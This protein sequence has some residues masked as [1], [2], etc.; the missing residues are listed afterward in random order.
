LLPAC[1][2]A[3]FAKLAKRGDSPID[4]EPIEIP[5]PQH[6][7]CCSTFEL[8]FVVRSVVEG[9]VRRTRPQILIDGDFIDERLPIDLRSLV[10]SAIRSGQH[11]I[12]TC[13][14]GDAGCGGVEE[15]IRVG[16][17]YGSILW[18]YRLPQS[19]DGFGDSEVS[20]Y[21]DWLKRAMRHRRI[22]NRR[23]VV[24]ALFEALSDAE[25]THASDAEYG[26]YGFERKDITELLAKVEKLR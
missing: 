22:F 21:Q 20:P 14:C 17:R 11:Y 15:G 6:G 10:K 18:E 19:T 24:D 7:A 25:A 12:Y 9:R 5:L 23:Q 13:S 3:A 26:P 1:Q 2:P 16:H 8:R 4:S